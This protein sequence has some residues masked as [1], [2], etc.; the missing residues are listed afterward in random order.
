MNVLSQ[1]NW[2]PDG[3]DLFKMSITVTKTGLSYG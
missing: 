3:L 1:A 2:L